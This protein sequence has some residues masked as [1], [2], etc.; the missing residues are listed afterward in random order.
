MNSWNIKHTICIQVAAIM[1]G[2]PCEEVDVVLH[3]REG[4]VK[5]ISPCHRSYDPLAYVLLN[6]YGKDGW[7]PGLKDFKDKNISIADF[8]GF[9][10]QVE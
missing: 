9:Y 6:P 7:T 2:E 1:P 5:Q 3:L 10:I 4:G 8:Y